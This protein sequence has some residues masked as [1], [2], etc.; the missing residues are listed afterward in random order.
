M[1]RIGIVTRFLVLAIAAIAAT[2][3]QKS[4]SVP[5]RIV[6]VTIATLR[7]DHVG[8]EGYPLPITP[9]LDSLAERGV[10]FGQA[11]AQAPTT[12]PSHA[13]I[14]T[15]LYPIQHR[16]QANGQK[17]DP[18]FVTLA[19]ALSEGGFRTAAF[20]STN[21]HFKWGALGQG[22][23]VY[24]EQP[25]ID[26]SGDKNRRRKYRPA[27][28]TI[29]AAI[30]WLAGQEADEKLFLWIHV[31]DPHKP[32]QPPEEFLDEVRQLSR[33]LGVEELKDHLRAAHGDPDRRRMFKDIQ[34]YDAEILYVDRQ[35]HRLYEALAKPRSNDL[36][37][38]TSDHGQGLNSHD[39]WMGHARQIYEVQ[40]RVPLLFFSTRGGLS[41]A[42][43]D[44]SLVEHVDL[45]PTVAELANLNFEQKLGEVQGVSLVPYLTRETS[46]DTK[47]FSLAQ[48]SWYR[49]WKKGRANQSR[50]KLSLRTLES[51]YISNEGDEDEFYDLRADPN[52]RNNLIH[53]S[54]H[55]AERD[56]M[57]SSLLRLV[58]S[59]EN[60]EIDPESVD[61][62]TLE[63]LRA[64]GYLQ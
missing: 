8:F 32:L 29:D 7:A 59:L 64:L 38:V 28:E 48:N 44:N 40:M 4:L 18:V 19:E 47:G 46:R 49:R 23:D 5:D 30:E 9:F 39:G 25:L 36:W 20:V 10:V 53:S 43:V 61:D 14:F 15:G 45:V 27:G 26:E 22:F 34:R 33:K 17:L 16:V 13:S 60:L 1:L 56:R 54:E 51:K 58:E 63:R 21:A 12:G 57:K 3:C 55:A 50:P 35:L 31:Y 37:I 62:E 2:G 41:P 6:L 42:R 24:D 11:M 52:E